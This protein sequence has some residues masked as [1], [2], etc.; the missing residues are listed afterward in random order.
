MY[1]ATI[2]GLGY[3]DGGVE[4]EEDERIRWVI[5]LGP[6]PE[7]IDVDAVYGPYEG[8]TE[9]EEGEM[10]MDCEVHTDTESEESHQTGTANENGTSG[11]ESEVEDGEI[12]EDTELYSQGEE[13][14]MLETG[15]ETRSNTLPGATTNH[16]QGY[17]PHLD[18]FYT[19]AVEAGLYEVA[20][21]EQ[22]SRTRMTYVEA[23]VRE[24]MRILA[25]SLK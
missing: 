23:G 15:G 13:T 21:G 10:A 17:Y 18:A 5:S 16:A 1:L 6:Q 20:D 2:P 8:P 19:Q 3:T 7:A 14:A 11:S 22:A 4:E 24:E 25:E 9:V 12:S